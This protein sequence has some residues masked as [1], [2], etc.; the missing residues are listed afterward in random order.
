MLV[1]SHWFRTTHSLSCPSV[2][3]YD[4]ALEGNVEPEG[5]WTCEEV[6]ILDAKGKELCALK[7]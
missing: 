5:S 1:R 7:F 3:I 6:V 4:D 2:D